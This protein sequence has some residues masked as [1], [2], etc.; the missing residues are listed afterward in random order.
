[1]NIIV[2]KRAERTPRLYKELELQGIKD[3]EFWPGVYLPSVKASINAAH[4][5]IVEYARLAEWL[6][7]TIAEDD[8]Q[9][10]SPQSWAYYNEKKPKDF[11]IYLSM[12][13]LGQP[14]EEGVVREFTGM[15]LYTVSRRFY[16][17]FLGVD[18]NEHIDRALAGLGRYVV[19][20]PFVAKQY[21]GWSGNTGKYEDYDHLLADRK[22][23]LG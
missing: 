20:S 15:T 2:G 9:F 22:F 18:D 7:V 1:M 3:F 19:C 13:Y 4:K 8:I 11:D 21:N 14:N 16:D 12:V 10:T 17:T 6:E 5:Q 23:L